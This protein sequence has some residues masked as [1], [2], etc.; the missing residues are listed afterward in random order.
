MACPT[1]RSFRWLLGKGVAS[2]T[3]TLNATAVNLQREILRQ[4]DQFIFATR[5]R[6]P[7][8]CLEQFGVDN[9]QYF[10]VNL[11]DQNGFST[12]RKI[13]RRLLSRQHYWPLG[14]RG[15]TKSKVNYWPSQ[16]GYDLLST[17]IDET[18]TNG[19]R[20]SHQRRPAD[21]YQ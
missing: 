1:H 4:Y 6:L 10:P 19:Q 12:Q 3:A 13:G 17:V 11:I 9:I 14:L 16:R 7:Q 15:L 18:K 21:Y 8:N 20:F 2:A 5:S